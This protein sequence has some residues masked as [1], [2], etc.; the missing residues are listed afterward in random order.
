[1]CKLKLLV[2]DF[3]EAPILCDIPSTLKV[4]H[5]KCCPMETLP[6]TDQHYELVEI[7]LPDS[8]IVQLW[9]GK[10]V[11][12]KLELLNLSCCYKLKETPDLSGAP[13][14]KILN[15]EHC[16]ELNYVHPSL[17]LH[18]SLVELNLT[19]CY[20]IETLADK[21]E[22]CSLETL[23]LDCCTR[24]RRLPEFGECM[25]QLSILILTYTD[26][27]E[28]PTTLGNLA[29][30]SELDLTG[31]DKLT[32][33]PLTGCFLKKLELHGFVELSCLPHEAP[34]LESLTVT[35]YYDEFDSPNIVGFFA[36]SL[37]PEP[38]LFE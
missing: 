19:G 8:K 24:L 30:V 18:K 27:E 2:L 36:F 13:V 15:L 29:G 5:W 38:D 26:I 12:K 33:L 4:L 22:M 6:F 37:L 14:L 28:V 16:R 31:C 20:S 7:H 9:D 21:L 10:K 1:M 3:V 35:A 32:S 25:K 11:L 17:A 34:R 23:G